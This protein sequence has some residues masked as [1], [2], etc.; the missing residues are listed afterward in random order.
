M[1]SSEYRAHFK[2]K[3]APRME[4][5]AIGRG[6]VGTKEASKDES[7]ARLKSSKRSEAD[8]ERTGV[9]EEKV[10][11]LTVRFQDMQA[12]QTAL[13]EAAVDLAGK[14]STL[15]DASLRRAEAFMQQEQRFRERTDLGIKDVEE[16]TAVLEPR[17]I[18]SRSS[19]P[20]TAISNTAEVGSAGLSSSS[21]VRHEEGVG[22]PSF[23]ALRSYFSK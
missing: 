21:S 8:P 22:L 13:N 14:V 19:T 9:L 18:P 11:A 20:H 4:P 15:V 23:E 5:S 10:K 3:C 1:Y 2:E 12:S 16:L 6:T 17:G 7:G